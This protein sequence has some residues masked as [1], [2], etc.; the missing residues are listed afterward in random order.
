MKKAIIIV[1]TM[2]VAGVAIAHWYFSDR[3]RFTTDPEFTALGRSVSGNDLISN[4][5]PAVILRFGPSFRYVGGQKFVLYGVADTEQHFFVE[6]TANDKLKSVYW[7][8]YEAYLPDKL[9]T[10]DY[11][12]SPLRVTL[13]DHEFY[14]DTDVVE[15]DSNRKRRRGTDGAAARQFLASKG[16]VFPNDFAYARLV[17]LTDES[18]QK[19]L[20]I[21]FIDDLAS[22]GLTAADLKEGGASAS[23]WA[24]VEQTHLD[25]IRNTLT[26][27][28]LRIRN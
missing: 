7:V 28:P 21:I 16:Y 19:E 23:R 22:R 25:R 8:Q 2:V 12:D 3:G 26:V 4:N 27:L 6:T 9:Y 17:Y 10:Y 1:A 18:R 15:F 13:N 20:M 24:K 5:D 14:T 11:D